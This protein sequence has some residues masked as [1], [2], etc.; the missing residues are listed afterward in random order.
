MLSGP[1][2]GQLA[3]RAARHALLCYLDATARRSLWC[4]TDEGRQWLAEAFASEAAALGMGPRIILPPPGA[5]AAAD[6]AAYIRQ[7]LAALG[8]DDLVLSV[9]SWET[10]RSIPYFRALPNLRTPDGFAGVSAVIRQRYPDDALLS[11][12]L[13]EPAAADAIVRERSGLA[14]A[15]RARV[16]TPG[17]TDVRLDLGAAHVLPYRVSNGNRHAY[18][19]PSEISFGVAAGSAD[20]EIVVDLT[21]GECVVGGEVL[22][23]LGLVDEPVRLRVAGGYV[24]EVR[25][26]EVARRLER[27]LERAGRSSRL[28][29]E[30]GFGLS[31]GTG[32]PAAPTGKIG[33]D[34]CLQGTCHFGLG[35]DSFYGK[36]NPSSLHLDVVCGGPVGVGGEAPV[37]GPIAGQA[38]GCA[39]RRP[40]PRP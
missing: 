6:P 16:I 14:G 8:P 32:G 24:T 10:A 31:A 26:G 23:P 5:A 39:A 38:N 9:F 3:R 18:L 2:R 4:F 28:V 17:G 15:R 13:T 25:G 27:C 36:V 35:D 37:S 29:V 19:P 12:L 33:P 40:G 21:V 11:H 30:L 34:E 20:G 22:D 1:D 7:A